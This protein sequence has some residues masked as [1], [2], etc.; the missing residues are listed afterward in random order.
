M[1]ERF[2]FGFIGEL[3]FLVKRGEGG[4]APFTK[5]KRGAVSE[6]GKPSDAHRKVQDSFRVVSGF[7][8]VHKDILIAKLLALPRAPRRSRPPSGLPA[9]R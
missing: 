9:T 8:L 2:K 4:E 1:G 6:G 3:G 7:Y 5:R